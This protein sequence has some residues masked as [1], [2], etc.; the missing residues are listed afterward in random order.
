MTKRPAC[1]LPEKTCTCPCGHKMRVPTM[2]DGDEWIYAVCN[3]T[4]ELECP[5]CH[6]HATGGNYKTG[7][8]ANWITA[9]AA[10]ES[11]AEYQRQMFDADMNEFYGR[12]NW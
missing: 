5:K 7:I 4:D 10:A 11:E 2:L 1:D 8:V 3:E 9:K 12:G 6:R